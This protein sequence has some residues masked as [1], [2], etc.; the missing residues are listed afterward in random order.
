MS[1]TLWIDTSE[2]KGINLGDFFTLMGDFAA[3]AKVCGEREYMEYEELFG[4]PEASGTNED[5]DPQW[6]KQVQEQ[7]QRFLSRYKSKLTPRAR[8]RLES[9]SK[10][11]G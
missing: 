7:A 8:H 10:M 5:C 9:L 4:V 1:Q 3:M 11:M 2:N 6:L